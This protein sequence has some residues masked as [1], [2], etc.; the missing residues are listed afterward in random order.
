MKKLTTSSLKSIAAACMLIDHIAAVF[1]F[2]PLVTDIMRGIGR[3][4][5]PLFAFALVEGYNHTRS[6]SHYI[7]R[8]GWFATITEIC[9]DLAFYGNW[10]DFEAQNV[11]FTFLISLLVL[12]GYS[13]YKEQ[14]FGFLFVIIGMFVAALLRTDHHLFGVLMVFSFHYYRNRPQGYIVAIV[15][16]NAIMALAWSIQLVAVLSLPIIAL[17]NGERGKG[18]KY[19]FYIFYPGHLLL[20]YLIRIVW[21]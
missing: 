9:F 1:T 11:L 7:L 21:G 14:G 13:R 2:S 19:I 10:I 4:S 6:R 15:L 5:F 3:L 20:L 18:M 16:I 8:M 12:E 17:Y